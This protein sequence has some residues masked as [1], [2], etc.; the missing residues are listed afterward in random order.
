[1]ENLTDI[2]F[3]ATRNSWAQPLCG[4]RLLLDGRH[5]IHGIDP[6]SP[7]SF[8]LFVTDQLLVMHATGLPTRVSPS[9]AHLPSKL[10][11][12]RLPLLVIQS[13]RSLLLILPPTHNTDVQNDILATKPNLF[14]PFRHIHF[15][16][17][18]LHRSFKFSPSPRRPH[19]SRNEL[20]NQSIRSRC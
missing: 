18:H 14:H 1:M 3:G 12:L 13:H 20:K 8:S 2:S 9:V 4:S 7:C 19:F 15:A 5:I 6:C 11:H 16:H 17:L 10:I